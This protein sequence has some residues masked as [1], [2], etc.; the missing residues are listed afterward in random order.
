MK[1]P[2]WVSKQCSFRESKHVVAL[3]N[4]PDV[5][6]PIL[7]DVFIA[8]MP[9][10]SV[11]LNHEPVEWQ[12]EIHDISAHSVLRKKKDAAPQQFVFD[13]PLQVRFLLANVLSGSDRDTGARVTAIGSVAL[14]NSFP[15]ATEGFTANWAGVQ[16]DCKALPPARFATVRTIGGMADF[17]FERLPALS[18]FLSYTLAASEVSAF[19]A[20]V[21][22]TGVFEA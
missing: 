5:P 16:R 13:N 19:Q 20:T 17:N 12:K 11:N 21:E 14:L 4:H 1:T 6:I 15:P 18:A 3:V 9:I 10:F 7:G 22:A 2:L 8:A